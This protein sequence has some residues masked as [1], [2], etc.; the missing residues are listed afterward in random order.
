MSFFFVSNMK[1][2]IR[3]FFLDRG[4][5]QLWKVNSGINTEIPT[6]IIVPQ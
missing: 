6:L 3:S 1:R 2:S 5:L 4:M